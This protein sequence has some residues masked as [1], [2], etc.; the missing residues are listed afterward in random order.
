[1][2][3]IRG[4][5]RLTRKRKR[6]RERSG[7]K[8]RPKPKL[9]K[10]KKIINFEDLPGVSS[11]IAG[12]LKEKYKSVSALKKRAKYEDLLRLPGLGDKRVRQILDYLRRI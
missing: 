6:K 3:I 2:V 9:P 5:P 11:E 4:L 10:R 1:M 12:L 8:A 7:E